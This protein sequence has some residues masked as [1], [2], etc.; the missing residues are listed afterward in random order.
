[1]QENNNI[2]ASVVIPVYNGANIIEPCLR[3]IS[4]QK[5]SKNY[6]IIVVD[7]GSNDETALLVKQFRNVRL[8]M[9]PNSG[10]AAA[11]NNGVKQAKGEIIVF[12]DADCVAKREFL[13]E[14]VKPFKNGNIAGVQGSYKTRQ[15]EIIARITQ[16]EIEERY[17]KMKKRIYIDH[18]G[19]Y[20]AAYRRNIFLGEAGFDTS[21]PKAS[22]E[23]TEFS[24]RLSSKGHKLQ[25]NPNAVV[26]HTHPSTLLQYLK[27]NFVR[28]FFRIGVY[29]KHTWKIVDDSYSS[30]LLKLQIIFFL[31][32]L[33][34]LGFYFYAL[35]NPALATHLPGIGVALIAGGFFVML[36]IVRFVV[37]N[38][39][40]DSVASLAYLA[41]GLF[42]VAALSL[43]VW[44]GFFSRGMEK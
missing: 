24:Y 26:E 5:F 44:K 32:T 18:I 40:K 9:Q 22:G 31:P 8:I 29:K 14:I 11:R 16:L 17:E 28:G 36:P 43:G 2:C 34:A 19:S 33:I 20:A 10:P 35:S 6:E 4:Q 3:A 13:Q 38:I 30:R 21:F 37:L 39:L 12:M 25:F 7:D 15:K 42:R 23:D 1:L 27:V 41:I